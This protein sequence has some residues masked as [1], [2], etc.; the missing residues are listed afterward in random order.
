MPE[1]KLL[2]DQ[3][4]PDAI[5]TV[6]P[7]GFTLQ[8]IRPDA[9]LLVPGPTPGDALEAFNALEAAGYDLSWLVTEP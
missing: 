2:S 8:R 7:F 6:A 4:L 3:N 1:I 9:V 5:A